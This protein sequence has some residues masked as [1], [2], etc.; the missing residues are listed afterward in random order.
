MVKL[1]IQFMDHGFNLEINSYPS[2]ICGSCLT[3]LYLKKAT[4]VKKF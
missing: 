3:S 2:G 1:G 4:I